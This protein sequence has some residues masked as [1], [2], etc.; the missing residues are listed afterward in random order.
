MIKAVLTGFSDYRAITNLLDASTKFDLGSGCNSKSTK[1]GANSKN[2]PQP[3][4]Q[5]V[6][7]AAS[8]SQAGPA[9]PTNKSPACHPNS[10][11]PAP[12]WPPVKPGQARAIVWASLALMG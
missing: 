3:C 12:N 11:K 10:A 5:S 6:Q 1:L 7:P 2:N 4:K 8:M 9:L